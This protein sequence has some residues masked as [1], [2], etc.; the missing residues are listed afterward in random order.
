MCVCLHLTPSTAS[1]HCFVHLSVHNVWLNA[2]NRCN[3]HLCHT[4]SVWFQNFNIMLTILFSILVAFQNQ[5][6][7]HAQLLTTRIIRALP[8]NP[9]SALGLH[10]VLLSHFLLPKGGAVW[11][12]QHSVHGCGWTRLPSFHVAMLHSVMM[13][14]HSNTFNT[15]LRAKQPCTNFSNVKDIWPYLVKTI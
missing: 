1:G 13:T 5:V 9:L 15:E 6:Y 14:H 7:L 2:W 10:N 3:T 12:S 4:A 11:L 8:L